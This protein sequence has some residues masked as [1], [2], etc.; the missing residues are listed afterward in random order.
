[1]QEYLHPL[2]EPTLQDWEAAFPV[3]DP[4]SCVT[5]AKYPKMPPVT[6]YSPPS[7]PSNHSWKWNH[8]VSLHA[9][10]HDPCSNT[11]GTPQ[12]G[13]ATPTLP[14]NHHIPK[15]HTAV[16]NNAHP[17]RGCYHNVFG[18]TATRTQPATSR[19]RHT[20]QV[21]MEPMPHAL[22]SYHLME[23]HNATTVEGKATISNVALD[24]LERWADI[25]LGAIGSNPNGYK[26]RSSGPWI[27]GSNTC[28]DWNG[29][30]PWRAV[31]H[32]VRADMRVEAWLH[33]TTP[34][35]VLA[36]SHCC[37]I[38]TMMMWHRSWTALQ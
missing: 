23:T 32:Y 37:H 10:G 29:R 19:A 22:T 14:N 24:H 38:L 15:P 8:E 16:P 36:M 1:M 11:E 3:G 18:R 34:T 6:S 28:S 35:F 26:A 17:C 20:P 33:V 30:P 21:T 27:P 31:A 13:P 9:P 5:T 25:T 12:K 4:K 2:G 7:P